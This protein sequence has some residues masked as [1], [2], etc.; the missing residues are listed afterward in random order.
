MRENDYKTQI[1]KFT[2]NDLLDNLCRFIERHKGYDDTS[3]ALVWAA[4]HGKA[5]FVRVLK[6]VSQVDAFGNRALNA[7]VKQGHMECVQL[8]FPQSD[9]NCYDKSLCT[10][11]IFNQFA[12]LQWILEQTI[13][14]HRSIIQAFMGLDTHAP[15]QTA[16]GLLYQYAGRS[17][18]E[19]F[20][21]IQRSGLQGTSLNYLVDLEEWACKEDG[22][23]I[24]ADV[25]SYINSAQNSASRKM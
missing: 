15:N 22:E 24:A 18:F 11:V 19:E 20:L 3:H 13:F 6:P 2:Q 21:D 7:A 8:L 14:S 9:Y 10:A 16:F 12:V 1:L 17:A 5:E 4:T 23:K 25:D